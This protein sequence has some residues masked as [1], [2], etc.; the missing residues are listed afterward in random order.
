[1]GLV[2]AYGF[3]FL[4]PPTYTA[5]STLLPPQQQQSAAASAL[6]SLGTLA[7]LAGGQG[8]LRSPAD[9]YVAL[10]QSATVSDRMIDR[11]GLLQA[12][13]AKYRIDARK[14][15]FRNARFSVG[16][17]D[18]LITIEVDDTD[19]KRA[20]D[21]ANRYIEELRQITGTLAVSEAQQ[22]RAFFEQQLQASRDKLTTAQVALQSSGFNQG[23]LRAEPKA[24]AEGYARLKAELT[25][26]EIRLQVLRGS[27][28]DTTPEVRQQQS[29]VQSLRAQLART[30]QATPVGEGPDY[31]AKYREFK[32]QETLFDLF[33]RQY[34]IARVDESREGALIQ[35]VDVAMPPEKA[36]QPRRV[37]IAL[38]G[39]AGALMLAL[40][41][42]GLISPP[43][44]R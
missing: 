11:F 36:S 1:M 24:A 4:I 6:A 9:Q 2:L 26:S 21:M 12:Y 3:S 33:S 13:D 5:A 16:R 8:G 40:I 39:A 37:R 44:K 19:A 30:E 17:K 14:Q 42:I 18:G 41:W 38:L 10:M 15:L 32:Y 29:V 25:A 22:R 27:L 43:T 20:A 28:S 23:A 31:V 34:E 7:G 35:V